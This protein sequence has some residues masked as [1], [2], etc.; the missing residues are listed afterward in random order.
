MEVKKEGQHGN[1]QEQSEKITEWHRSGGIKLIGNRKKDIYYKDEL[2]E[3]VVEDKMHKA[4]WL[5]PPSPK[6]DIFNEEEKV[7]K[8]WVS[9]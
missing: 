3:A 6:K 8:K 7:K 5:L 4:K 9:A 1:R 2:K